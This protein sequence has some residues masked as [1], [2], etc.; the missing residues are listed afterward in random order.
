MGTFGAAIF[1]P[2]TFLACFVVWK[3]TTS[4]G[5]L[6]CM[7]TTLLSLFLSDSKRPLVDVK[8]INET[9]SVAFDAFPKS[10]ATVRVFGSSI[11]TW[12]LLKQDGSP[13]CP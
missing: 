1:P 12:K 2:F 10:S 7:Y 13:V 11:C 9:C 3:S 4:T 6:S 8:H 5:L